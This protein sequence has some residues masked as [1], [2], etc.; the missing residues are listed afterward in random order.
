[1]QIQFK[2][3]VLDCTRTQIMGILNVTPD[4]FSDG[5]KFQEPDKALEHARQMIADGAAIIDVGGEST[6]PDANPLSEEQELQRVL[7]VVKA[8]KKELGCLVSVD[9]SSPLVMTECA[10]AGADMW[11]D[12]RALT[13]PHALE[14][15]V[16]LDIP[17]CLM[18]MQG[19]PQTMQQEPH[20]DNCVTEISD[21][22]RMRAQVCECAGIKRRNIILDP[23]FGFGKNAEHNYELLK[24][25]DVFCCGPYAVLAGL[26]RK[27]MIG[28]ATGQKVPAERVSGSVIGAIMCALKGAALVRVHDVAETRQALDVFFRIQEAR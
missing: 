10:K 12:I 22:L 17:V 26:S 24:H 8:I 13:R 5:G 7:P 11:N 18:H 3:K 9:T 16:K 4:S 20:Y 27:S 6:R 14:T 23:G 25:F 2:D 15:A 21:Y 1:M 28:A 19:D